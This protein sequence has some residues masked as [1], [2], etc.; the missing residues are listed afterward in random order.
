MPYTIN[1]IK[2]VFVSDTLDIEDILEQDTVKT[3]GG[4]M[5]DGN[6]VFELTTYL[7]DTLYN[8]LQLP[9]TITKDYFPELVEERVSDYRFTLTIKYGVDTVYFTER[10]LLS[11]IVKDVM[12]DDELMLVKDVKEFMLFCTNFD[13]RLNNFDHPLVDREFEDL[14]LP[15]K[16]KR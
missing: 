8:L 2:Y 15:T 16:L 5:Y 11:Y 14:T 12:K 13:Y 7:R 10:D 6:P 3:I 4:F 1:Q 9:D